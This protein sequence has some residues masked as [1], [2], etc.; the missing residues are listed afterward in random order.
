[1][2]SSINICFSTLLHFLSLSLSL[3]FAILLQKDQLDGKDSAG[4]TSKVIEIR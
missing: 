3:V 2:Y 1:M 4:S